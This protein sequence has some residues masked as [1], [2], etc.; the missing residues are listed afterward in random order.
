MEEY[1]K[2]YNNA[3][4]NNNV[5]A[6]EFL[7]KID[8]S[9]IRKVKDKSICWIWSGTSSTSGRPM[10]QTDYWKS[11]KTTY[12]HRISYILFKGEI[13]EDLSICHTCETKDIGTHYMCVNPYHLEQKTH[14]DNMKD[15]DNNLGSYQTEKTSGENCG[16][17]KFS[18]ED[19]KK[20]QKRHIDGEEYLDIATDLKVHKKTIQRICIGQTYGLPDC[21]IEIEKQKKERNKK[22]LEMLKNGKT[23]AFISKELKISTSSISTIKNSQI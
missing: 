23:P 15:R 10:Y 18:L 21:R 1:I 3:I 19:C 8:K 17:A 16:T 20:I 7:E 22:V 5:K 4:I 6:I 9:I 13:D 12:A 2:E 14:K 11:K